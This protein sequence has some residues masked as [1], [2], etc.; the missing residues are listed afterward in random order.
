MPNRWQKLSDTAGL[1]GSP[2][3]IGKLVIEMRRAL[4]VH[5]DID[6]ADQEA[7]SLRRL[8]YLVEQCSGPGSYSCPILRGEP[9]A[10]VGAAD[11]LV[12]DVW[13]TTES[14]GGRRLVEGL[15]DLHP[16]IPLVLTAPG[17]ELD[18]VA[19]EGPHRVVPLVGVPTGTRLAAAIDE[20]MAA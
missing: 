8:G 17:M 7:D 12:Y 5:H 16:D 19:T 14:D 15:R 4:V 9:C 11:V 1:E 2:T 3:D 18:W 10:A 6:M 13:A 20:A